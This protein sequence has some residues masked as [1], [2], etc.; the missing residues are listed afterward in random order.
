[1]SRLSIA[2]ALACLALLLATSLTACKGADGATGPAGPQGAQ[3]PQ[4]PQGP[5]G[6]Q[7]LPGPA[8]APGTTRVTFTAVAG[9]NGTVAVA[10]PA[11]AGS[12]PARPPFMSCYTHSAT[13]AGVWLAVSDGMSATDFWCGLVLVNGVWTATMQQMIPGWTAA[14]VVV[15]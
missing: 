5:A 13:G 9:A 2:R 10:L 8:G 7:G 3:G 1:M 12:D 14:F 11:A 15:Y 4:G 6:P